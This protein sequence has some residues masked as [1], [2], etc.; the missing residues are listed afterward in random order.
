MFSTELYFAVVR[1]MHNELTDEAANV[2]LV[3]ATEDPPRLL[4]RFLPDPTA[5]SRVDVRIRRDVVDRFKAITQRELDVARAALA[6]E[7]A[8]LPATDVFARIKDHTAGLVRML[9]PRVVL[10]NDVDAEFERLFEEWVAPL[11]H[12]SERPSGSVRDPLGGLRKEASRAIVRAFREGLEGPLVR[13]RFVRSYEVKGSSH[14]SRFDMAVLGGTRRKRHEHL[15]HHLLVMPDPEENFNQAAALCWR[16]QDV[17][18]ANHADR[19]LTAVLYGR[20]EDR[21]HGQ[22]DTLKLLKAESI[23]HTRV[24]DLPQLVRSLEHQGQFSFS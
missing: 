10:T 1:Y 4:S 24:Q 9:D 23:A 17:Q 5:K 13:K 21:K 2:G 18:A 11:A 12:K 6:G 8:S 15:F 20:G 14:R 16:W 7:R 22:G 3:A 19:Q